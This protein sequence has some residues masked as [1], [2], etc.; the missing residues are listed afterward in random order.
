M[1]ILEKYGKITSIIVSLIISPF[2]QCGEVV[3]FHIR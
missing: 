3:K 2:V 1:E